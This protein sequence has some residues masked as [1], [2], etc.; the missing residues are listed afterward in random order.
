MTKI[1][2]LASSLGGNPQIETRMGFFV[3]L[4]PLAIFI[5]LFGLSLGGQDAMEGS[6]IRQL[7]WAL[8][9]L[10]AVVHIF[11]N[12]INTQ[13]FN[14]SLGGVTIWLI[15]IFAFSSTLWSTTPQSTFKR[16]ILLMIVLLL[17]IAYFG[18]K[19]DKGLGFSQAIG[20]GLLPLIVASVLITAVAP[21][22]AITDIGWR[23][24]T[25]HKNELGQAIGVALLISIYGNVH[26]RKAGTW[27]WV[28]ILFLTIGLVITRSS[29]ALVAVSTAISIT[30]AIGLFIY[31]RQN[32]NWLRVFLICAMTCLVVFHI[33]FLADVLP[34]IADLHKLLLHALGKSE[35]LTGRT[36]L[37]EMVLSQSMYHNPLFGGGYGGFWVGLDSISAYTAHHNGLYAGQSHNGYIDIYNDIGWTGLILTLLVSLG[38]LINTLKLMLRGRSEWKLCFAL[39]ISI[40]VA[41]Y[42]E[43][44]LMRSTQFLNIVFLATVIYAQKLAESTQSKINS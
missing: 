4:F 30:S 35:T 19:Y 41:N 24:A 1:S 29:T 32:E 28:T 11:R 34:P 36:E 33:A 3:F 15:V 8:L 31:L 21:G 9:G 37:W 5:S 6:V 18:H 22:Y 26:R 12:S 40:L 13:G 17:A 20:T 7:T 23:G 27:R 25:T 38:A 16:A 10:I 14:F 2:K 42:S 43:S 39:L 44:T